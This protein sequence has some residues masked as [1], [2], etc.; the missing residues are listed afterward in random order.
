M[1]Q[2]FNSNNDKINISQAR[3]DRR[4]IG[5][6][7][8]LV[9]ALFFIVCL[10]RFSYIAL[11]GHV[12][13]VDL[14]RRTE[15]KYRHKRILSSKR[16]N[17][18]ADDGSKI[19]YS[20]QSYELFVVLDHTYK[21]AGGK[22]LYVQDK[23]HT[24]QIL[25]QYIPLSQKKILQILHPKNRHVFQVEFGLAGQKI[26]LSVKKAIEKHHL[27]GVYFD[28]VPD[29]SYPNGTFAS[30]TIGLAQV[31]RHAQHTKDQG[32][33][34]L[35]SF[36]DKI[37]QGKNGY[38][39]RY[40]D[41]E[42]YTLPQTHKKTVLP[43]Q[44]NNVYTTIDV[45][46][47]HYLEQLLTK[48][49]QEYRPQSMQA[50]VTDPR[51][52]HILAISQR[53][54]FD[55]Q[56]Q[57]NL[58]HSWRN[59][60]L[61]DS[62][63][64]GSVFKVLTLAASI[65]SHHY[66]PNQYYRSGAITIGGRTIH[67]W[68]TSGWGEI[69]FNQAFPRSSN[70]G[71][72]ALEQQMGAKTWLK[73]MHKFKIGELTHINLPG[74]VAGQINFQHAS[75]QA[76]TAF[77]QSVSVTGMQMVQALGA[78]GNHGKMMQPQLV[79][80]IENPNNG[81]V[82]T[83][84]PKQ[85]GQ[86]VTDRT[87]KQVL[88]AMREVVQD[89]Y[90]TGTVYKIPGQD[91]AVKTGTAQISGTNGYLTGSND[92][93]YSV[94]GLAPAKSPKYLVYITM[95]KPSVMTKA[96]E[97]MLSEVFNP[98]MQRLLGTGKIENVQSDNTAITMPELSN[99]NLTTVQQALQKQQLKVGIVGTGSKVVQQLPSA[100]AA[101]TPDQ[102]V[103]LLTNG[104]MTMPDVHGWSKNDLLKLADITGKKIV[105]KGQGYAVGQSVA[106]QAVL[107]SVKE[108]VIHLKQK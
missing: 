5:R 23:K 64:P 106:P 26:S 36:Y 4:I 92:Y 83:I 32:L 57:N 3:R 51:T 50:I 87:T 40:T 69:P 27:P 9:I 61:Q 86:P 7:F 88:A 45:N 62:Y 100:K 96:P 52:G 72:V 18:Y 21:G 56:T 34:G 76:I 10:A 104:A 1:S 68:N 44:G 58:M 47:Q 82:Q 38:E 12:G 93:L 105:I 11:S 13:S 59:I 90:G 20:D 107:N 14:T 97:Q 2:K 19:A 37:L 35:E 6:F 17:I 66:N 49:Y 73:Y 89:S 16:G 77:G 53:P 101:V 41:P 30:N 70:V 29:R 94:A 98:M 63:E 85:V 33:M 80:R 42:G 25:S 43:V 15:Q 65:N 24:A 74:E 84:K 31:G 55:P 8:L 108:V 22:P 60:N 48:V 102:R 79:S 39:I 75:D 28:A 46:Y 71:M 95:E 78:I 54:T 67:D 103:I 81:S 91:V 99:Q